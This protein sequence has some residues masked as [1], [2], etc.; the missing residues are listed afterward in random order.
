MCVSHLVHL[1]IEKWDNLLSFEDIF[2]EICGQLPL[3]LSHRLA[4]IK[5]EFFVCVSVSWFISSL[6]NRKIG[7][8][9]QFSMFF[10]YQTWWKSSPWPISQII[11]NEILYL[12]CWSVSWFFVHWKMEKLN[13]LLSFQDVFPKMGGRFLTD[14]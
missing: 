12:V 9:A 4:R 1:S 10:F 6:K 13:I 2:T 14:L 8:F 3:D 11:K 7:Y 5:F